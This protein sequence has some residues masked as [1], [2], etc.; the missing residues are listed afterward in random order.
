LLDDV[1]GVWAIYEF[2]ISNPQGLDIPK[3]VWKAGIDFE[4]EEGEYDRAKS[5]KLYEKF[6]NKKD[7]IKV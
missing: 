7:Y 4:V 1:D 6:L 5:F 3:T 2:V